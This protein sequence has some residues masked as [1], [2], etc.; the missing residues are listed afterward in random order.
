MRVALLTTRAHHKMVDVEGV[1]TP[2]ILVEGR[3]NVRTEG[4]EI[5]NLFIPVLNCKLVH[6]N[7]PTCN[8]DDFCIA[9]QVGIF[10]SPEGAI[11]LG[12]DEDHK[13]KALCFLEIKDC[14]KIVLPKHGSPEFIK[15]FEFEE[16]DNNI[17]LLVLKMNKKSSFYVF[18]I[19]DNIVEHEFLYDYVGGHI[20]HKF[21]KIEEP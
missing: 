4:M 21:K 9:S 10:R 3:P 20:E 18:D 14:E 5:S 16:V 2:G 7:L 13:D 12:P 6:Y 19:R 1:E 17:Y 8:G 15:L 11:F